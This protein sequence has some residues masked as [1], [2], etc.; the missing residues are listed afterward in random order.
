[1]EHYGD[2]ICEG[3]C[4]DVRRISRTI[5]TIGY[6]SAKCITQYGRSRATLDATGHSHRASIRPLSPRQMQWS[7]ILA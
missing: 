5:P 7:S 6:L 4:V 1:M 3:S 2:D